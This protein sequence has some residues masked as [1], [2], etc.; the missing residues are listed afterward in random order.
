MENL[1]PEFKNVV[2]IDVGSE[3]TSM[4]VIKDGQLKFARSMYITIGSIVEAVSEE[5][6]LPERE[7]ADFISQHGFKIESYPETEEGK[8]YKRS[9]L[10]FLDRFR[11]EL[12]RS[13]LF[14]QEKFGSGDRVSKI[15]LT[16]GG[17]GVADITEFLKERLKLEIET[18]PIAK[19]LIAGDDFKS[20]YSLYASSI[21]GALIS[22]LKSKFN[23]APK[24]EKDR[25][26]R[27]IHLEIAVVFLFVYAAIYY[28]HLGYKNRLSVQKK[29]L[30]QI[31]FEIGSYPG[32][33]EQ[34]YKDVLSKREDFSELE[35]S[36]LNLQKPY[37][38]WKG[39]F[40]E[41]S[42]RIDPTM[43]VVDFWVGFNSEGAMVFQIQGEYE[44][45]YPNAQLVLRK[46]R[47][48]FEESDLFQNI[49]FEIQRSGK[50][51]IGE[52][53]NYPYTMAGYI[54][55]DFLTKREL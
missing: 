36:F 53:R 22:D 49:K 10:K 8:K 40:T 50:V 9:I 51:K 19:R 11:A 47:L 6:N 26:G 54:N 48:S 12:Q 27:R 2:L 34:E 1:Y 44:G 17:L 32:N 3:L 24:V 28:L 55:S 52:I 16:G 14:Y 15:V 25:T 21:G 45:T 33:L 46:A 42:N 13:I 41:I 29:Q 38:E 4:V 20:C 31:Q 7:V 30:N 35:K 39:F 5:N 37:I 23:L 18:L 43:L